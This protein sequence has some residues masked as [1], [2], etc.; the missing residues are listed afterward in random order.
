MRVRLPEERNADIGA[1]M[2]AVVLDK[3]RQLGLEHVTVHSG[4]EAIH[5]YE[6]TGFTASPRVLF[7]DFAGR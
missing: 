1:T 7:A 2:M 5:L 4:P 3:V 6:R